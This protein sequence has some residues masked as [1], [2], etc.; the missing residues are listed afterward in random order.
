MNTGYKLR[1]IVHNIL[2]DI[3]NLEIT[4]DT[5][6][7][8][9]LH[10][11]TSKRD[12]AFINTV[13]LNTMRYFFHSKKILKKYARRKTKIH[14]EILLYSAITQIV[15]LKFKE[16]A[17]INET[18]EISKK[19]KLYPGYVNACLRKISKE[20]EILKKT[21]INYSEL[22]SW[23]KKKTENLDKFQIKLFIDNFYKEPDIHLVFKSKKYLSSFEKDLFITSEKSGFLVKKQR[24]EEIASF[25]RGN[26]WVQD[27]SSSFPLNNI[28]NKIIAK[29]CLD[30]CAAPGGKSFQVLS[31]KKNIVLNDKSKTR[32]MTLKENLTRLAFYPTIT[33]FD[34]KKISKKNLY[35]FIIV[36][37]PCS[38]VGTIRK[39]PEIFYRKKEPDFN[40]LVNVQ[41]EM[42]EVASQLLKDNGIILYMVC[43]FLK[44]ETIDQINSFLS[45]HKQFKLSNFSLEISDYN[46]FQFIEND[47]MLILPSQLNKYNIDGY[48]A[49][50]LK[51]G[52]E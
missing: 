32:I 51:K 15:F 47:Q 49:A 34:F 20:K 24:I 12:I 27:F 44:I 8:K 16:Y 1:L 21:H 43:S 14:E 17:V 36:D 5:A 37:A 2:Y 26:W 23:F 38:A 7:N 45:K 22:P 4:F 6:L 9:Y 48:F 35:D 39:N 33:N 28:N 46:N 19:L 25:K 10:K 31:R 40:G 18:V 41:R 13:S 52:V 11:K 42:L 30:M 29:K 50:Y 3:Q